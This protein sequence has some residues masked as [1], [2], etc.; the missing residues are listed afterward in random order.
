M[1]VVEELV[2]AGLSCIPHFKGCQ[3]FLITAWSLKS[4]TCPVV[5]VRFDPPDHCQSDSQCAGAEKCCDSGCGLG[6]VLPQQLEGRSVLCDPIPMVPLFP[7]SLLLKVICN[8][9]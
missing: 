4:G 2:Q 6:C 9:E 7:C 5:T 1:G 8:E 3:L